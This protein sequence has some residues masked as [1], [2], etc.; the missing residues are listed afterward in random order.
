MALSA[1]A[2]R[3]TQA[4]RRAQAALGSQTAEW[5][6]QMWP[7]LNLGDLDGTFDDWL[8]LVEPIVGAQRSTSA[9]LAANYLTIFRQLELGDSVAPA[10]P[11]LVETVPAE[12]LA[13]SLRVT[14]PISVKS[15]LARGM[16]LVRAAAIAD[17]RTAAAG[18]RHAI[19]GGRETLLQ[20][21]AGDDQALGFARVTSGKSCAFCA[22][23]ASRG[24][25]Y[26]KHTVE[27][28][29]HDGCH[30]TTE[31]VY[32]TETDWPA[33]SRQYKALYDEH[34]K[35]TADPLAAFRRAYEAAR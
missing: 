24:P 1:D 7:A 16:E 3:L 6:R 28:H 35:G 18:M 21:A 31:V 11:V 19:D 32:D 23:I 17:E 12:A 33:G 30:C 25:V 13:T 4:H 9:R 10:D 26:S 34:A 5:V 8:A 15:N 29:S 20:T 2:A 27:F 22:L 14:G